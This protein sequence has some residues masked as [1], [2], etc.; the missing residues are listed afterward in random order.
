[1]N[2]K[3]EIYALLDSLNCMHEELDGIVVVVTPEGKA[4]DFTIPMEVKK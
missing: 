3:S 4:W 1:M 2:I